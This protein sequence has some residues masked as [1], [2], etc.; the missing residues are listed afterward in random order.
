MKYQYF[1]LGQL[2]SGQIVEVTLSGSAANVRLMDSANFAS[3]KNNRKHHYYGGLITQ[4]PFRLLVPRTGRWYVTVDLQGLKGSTRSSVRVLPG[5]LPEIHE[6]PLSSIPSLV[7]H[8]DEPPRVDFSSEIYDVFISYA[9]EDKEDIASPLAYSLRNHGLCVWFDEFEM[10]IGDSIRRKID[11]G[12]ARSK[13][14]IVVLS[15]HFFRKGWTNYELDGIVTRSVTGE[16]ILLPIWHNISK[17]E[18]INFSPSLAEKVARNTAMHTLEEIAEEINEL[19]K[20][21]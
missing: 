21:N 13:F 19:I 12:L 9:S 11:Q 16:Q 2:I 20:S 3:Y 1:D 8:H 6:A 17:Q 14:G 5:P 7:R 15:Q 4:S 10:K 18:V